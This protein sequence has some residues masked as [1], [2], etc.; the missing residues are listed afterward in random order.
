MITNPSYRKVKSVAKDMTVQGPGLERVVLETMRTIATIV[1]ATLGPGGCPVLIERQEVG[2]P[3]MVTKDGVTVFRNLGFTNATQHAIMEAARDASIRTATEAGDG[4]TTATI[5]SEALVRYTSEF[6][7]DNKRYSPQRVIRVIESVFRSELEPKLR[8]L[9][10]AATPEVQKAV[11]LCSSNGDVELT[12]AVLEC[13]QLTGDDGNVTILERQGNSGYKVEP[14]KGYAI[15]Q[16]YEESCRRFF[17]AF[18]NDT[19]NNQVLLEKPVLCLYFGQI[20]EIQTLIPLMDAVGGRWNADKSAP[21]NVVVLATGFSD[22]VLASLATNFSQPDTIRVYPLVIPR[23]A[24]LNSEMHVLQDVAAL[25]GASVFDPLN[26]PLERGRPEDLGMPLEYFESG[27]YRS[28]IVGHVD[29]DLLL[30]RVADVRK[31]AESP[32]SIYDKTVTE[33]RLAKLTGGIAKLFV[34]GASSGEIREKRDRAED[35]VCALRGALKHGAL[36][37]GCWGLM[38]CIKYL[39]DSKRSEEDTVIVNRILVPALKEP[40][41]RLMQNSGVLFADWSNTI[42]KYLEILEDGNG[43][44]IWDA[45][46]GKFTDAA[47]S[48]VVDSLPAVVEALRNSISIA[49]LLGTLGGCVVFQRDTEVERKES[50][51][52]YSYLAN[53]SAG[54]KYLQDQGQA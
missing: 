22:M 3:N 9:K 29:D 20:T 17:S 43:T 47:K 25:S 6:L 54:T 26:Y 1:G 33:E 27:R 24:V 48:G 12:K 49:T 40:F 19:G 8:G 52:A 38:Q 42:I 34:F 51:D 11:A 45:I 2:M 46:S 37:G 44:T 36:P 21:R 32:E 10:I 39:Q 13:F 50:G 4:T 7:R 18:I 53:T 5:L 23:N 28:N 41:Q 16:G 30:A 31:Q 15:A 14:L 35:A